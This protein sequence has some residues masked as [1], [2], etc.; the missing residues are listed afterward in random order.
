MMLSSKGLVQYAQDCYENL[1]TCYI[2]GGMMDYI[3]DDI[4]KILSDR[5]P[6]W[7]INKEKHYRSLV[8]NAYY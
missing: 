8:N 4:I 2:W 7:Y 1:R 5:Y 3:T 6:S